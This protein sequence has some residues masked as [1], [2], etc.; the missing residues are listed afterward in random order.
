MAHIELGQH[1]EAKLLAQSLKKYI[2][3]NGEKASARHKTILRLLL[4][5]ERKNFVF[6]KN[7]AP[8]LKQ[9]SAEE[10]ENKWEILSSELIPFNEWVKQKSEAG[11]GVNK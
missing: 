7:A 10:G 4:Q 11:K 1:S 6:D 8:L 9:L 2:Q 3:R 5:A